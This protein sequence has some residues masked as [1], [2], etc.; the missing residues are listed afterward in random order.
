MMIAGALTCDHAD[1]AALGACYNWSAC[2]AQFLQA[3]TFVPAATPIDG[4][5]GAP[6]LA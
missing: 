6:S 4:A 1:A 2:T 3:L 5:V